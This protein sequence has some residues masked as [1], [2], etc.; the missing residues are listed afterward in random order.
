MHRLGGPFQEASRLNFRPKQAKT[1]VLEAIFKDLQGFLPDIGLPMGTALLGPIG[2]V[3]VRG[4]QVLPHGV[5]EGGELLH[6]AS[7]P[8]FETNK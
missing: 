7:G 5:R 8:D 6:L 3:D 1:A 2:D 4:A